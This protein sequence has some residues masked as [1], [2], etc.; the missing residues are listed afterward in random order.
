MREKCLLH[1]LLILMMCCILKWLQWHPSSHVL[2]AGTIDGTHWMWH[3]PSGECK[4]FTGSG[5]PSECCQILHD[6]KR[7]A[8]GYGNGCV[9]IWDLKTATTLHNV[10]GGVCVCVGLSFMTFM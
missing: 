8:I 9:R 3:I 4:T 6:G 5:S 1:A 7:A 2:L 10:T